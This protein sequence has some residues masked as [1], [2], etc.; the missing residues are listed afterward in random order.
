MPK[1]KT[2]YD[3]VIHTMTQ[4]DKDILT[5]DEIV[6][7][8]NSD[9]GSSACSY[10]INAISKACKNNILIKHQNPNAKTLIKGHSFS[11]AK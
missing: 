10:T 5:C 6:A 4:S 2:Y 9:D 8:V 1:P 3:R 7:I 11:L